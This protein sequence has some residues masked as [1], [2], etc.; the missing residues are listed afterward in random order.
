MKK[1]LILLP[2]ALA[3]MLLPVFLLVRDGYTPPER[4]IAPRT[5]EVLYDESH[6]NVWGIHDTGFYGYS[7]FARLL[8]EHG[9]AVSPLTITLDKALKRRVGYSTG[10]LLV[11]NV[12]K[13]QHYGQEEL[14]AVENFVR[15]GGALLCIG[16]HENIYGSSDFQNQVLHRFA[17]EFKN[18]YVGDVIPHEKLERG[19]LEDLNQRAVSPIL[20]LRDVRHLLSAPVSPRDV[21]PSYTELLY[22]YREGKK[23]AIAAG[24]TCGRG[25]VAA[26]GDSE[27]FWNGDGRIGIG[28]GDNRRF[29]LRLYQW[30]L[31]GRLEPVRHH[32]RCD[33]RRGTGGTG[34]KVFIDTSSCGSGIDDS[35]GGLRALA[36]FLRGRG[37]S[38]CAGDSCGDYD[39]RLVAAPLSEV[40]FP[41]DGGERLILLAGSR[42]DCAT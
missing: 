34:R 28:A 1:A 22:G 13:F 3:I 35:P 31:D 30:L 18:D 12:A 27:L 15:T 41:R 9:I 19:D 32:A 42:N 40:A 39:V 2:I 29:L 6:G 8:R 37:H 17:M 10:K 24:R 7:E 38:V 26:V 36:G 21:A 16:E 33:F 5:V 20:G 14:A 4:V 25:R 11:L 23:I